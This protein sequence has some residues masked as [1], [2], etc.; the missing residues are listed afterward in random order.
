MLREIGSKTLES[1][2]LILRK[3][4]LDDVDGM[5]NNWGK[6]PEVS[7]MLYWDVHTNKDIT[8]NII[9]DWIEKYENPFTF[10]WVVEVKET[11]EIIGSIDVVRCKIKDETCEIGYC[12]G[13]KYWGLGYG[14]EALKRVIVFLINEVGF[15]LVEAHHISDNPASGIVM[16]KAG[17]KKDAILRFR[18]INKYTNKI[19]DLIIYS[20]IKE[21]L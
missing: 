19:N 1:D 8:F 20:I 16:K 2:R 4:T 17:M 7:K 12:Y 9:T 5:Y 10:R 15:R 11:K 21:E 18:A 14:S 3:F 6:D 13:S